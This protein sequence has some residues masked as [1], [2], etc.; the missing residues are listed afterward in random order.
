[1]VT[2]GVLGG[3]AIG[4][5]MGATFYIEP[6][7][8]FDL[9]VFVVL[10]QSSS[11]LL[12]LSPLYDHLKAQGCTEDGE[13]ILIEGIPVQF[14]PAYNALVEEALSEAADTDYE[15]VPTRVLTAEH[16][17]AICVQTGRP[18]DRQRVE[19]FLEHAE[20]D[21]P[22]LDGILQRYKLAQTFDSWTK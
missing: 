12:T 19:M 8:T 3:Y 17:L 9:D 21:R 16:L 5:A 18:K 11:G 6:V 1:M 14:L 13:C 2:Q 22:K 10:P 7:L 4:G 20:L 15:G